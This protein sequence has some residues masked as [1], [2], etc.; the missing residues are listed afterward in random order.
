MT[1]TQALFSQRR[2]QIGFLLIASLLMFLGRAGSFSLTN[3]DDAFYAQ[4]AK[5]MLQSGSY[6]TVLYHNQPSFENTPLPF[7][8]MAVN[9]KL[10]GVSAYT[11][12]LH[13]A[14]LAAATVLLTYRFAEVLFRQRWVAFLAGIVLVFPGFYADYARRAMVEST[15]VFFFT[16]A[17]FC[18]YKGLEDRRWFALY[19]VCAGCAVLSKSVLGIFPLAIGPLFLIL[20]GQSRRLVDPFF[21]LGVLL[22]VLVGGSWFAVSFARHGRD[23]MDFHFGWLILH[24][25]VTGSDDPAAVAK[26]DPFYFLNYFRYLIRNHWPWVPVAFYGLAV[27]IKRIF[28]SADKD[29]V[30]LFLVVWVGVVFAVMSAAHSQTLRYVF[31]IFPA[32]ALVTA[33]TIADH[34]SE[35]A[36]ERALPYMAGA[37]LIAVFLLNATPIT[38]KQSVSLYDRSLEIRKLAAVVHWN[39]RPG[40][41]IG[42]FHLSPW[43]PRN[44]LYFY[45]NRFLADPVSDPEELGAE[46]PATWLT[47]LDQ[48]RRLQG[49]YPDRFYLI[50]AQGN[51]AY[52]TTEA[53]RKRVRYDF[54]AGLVTE[55]D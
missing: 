28:S 39:T 53:R 30:C 2:M 21:V 51:Y 1:P 7:W 36:Q 4:K 48:F 9:F 49:E 17:L 18:F 50:M 34:L 11:A 12:V 45:S 31:S 23:F 27:F 54:P 8:L 55:T 20:S 19:G 5:E 16:A 40:E 37:V 13:S 26:G 25:G 22:A 14:L 43:N 52:F 47:G 38:I 44:A 41:D 35:N 24:R 29:R 3:S 42:N 15:L 46:T 33:K 6:W 10:F 32:L